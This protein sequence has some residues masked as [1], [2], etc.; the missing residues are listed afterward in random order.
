MRGLLIKDFK[1]M[2]G[3]KNFFLL[4]AAI[5]FFMTAASGEVSFSF[6]FLTFVVSL[7]SLSTI[8]YDGFDNGNA[9]L[10]TLPISRADY[11]VEKYCFAL[12]LG[13]GSWVAAIILSVIGSVIKGELPFS[14]IMMTAAS[15]LPV[16]FILQAIMI[17]FQLK[18]G[19]E[20]ARIAI[21]IAFTLIAVICIAVIKCASMFGIDI[22]NTL[23]SFSLPSMGIL[24][25]V[26][27]AA[28][29]AFL[30]ISMRISI[31]IMQKKEF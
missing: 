20:K 4:I 31:S 24:L 15:I 25:A 8:T 14:E 27:Y 1:L 21:V 13:C 3:Q 11:V 22:V 10:F 17:P 7:F 18:F 30:L 19:G 12:L 23:E 29:I 16:L 5:A 2:R 28:T 6:G 26:I 9:F